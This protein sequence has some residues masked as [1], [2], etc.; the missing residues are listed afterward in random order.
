MGGASYM[1]IRIE[2][3]F[4]TRIFSNSE[5]QRKLLNHIKLGCNHG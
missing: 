2:T 3:S 5:I 4:F 1:R